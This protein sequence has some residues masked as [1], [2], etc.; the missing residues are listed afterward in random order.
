MHSPIALEMRPAISSAKAMTHDTESRAENTQSQRVP[1]PSEPSKEHMPAKT[2]SKVSDHPLI[3]LLRSKNW[4]NRTPKEEVQLYGH[5][6]TGCGKQ[7]DYETTTKLGEGTFGFAFST[8]MIS[9][10]LTINAIAKC[11][12]PFIKPLVPSLH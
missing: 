12:K 7:A 8:P 4:S 6:F 5:G 11:T 3:Q 1:P 2:D 9:S 10:A